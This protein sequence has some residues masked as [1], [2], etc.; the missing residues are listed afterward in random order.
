MTQRRLPG[1]RVA[2]ALCMS[3]LCSLLLLPYS[4]P[5]AAHGGGTP[6][7]T[8]VPVGPYHLYAWSDPEPWRAGEVHLSL[9][10]TRPNPDTSSNQVEIPVTDV[11]ITVTYTP[12]DN[13]GIDSSSAPVV[14]KAVRQEFLSDFYYEADP[15]LERV[16]DWQ[17]TIDVAGPDGS[18][19][20]Q[21]PMETLPA[22]SL[23]WTLIGAAGGVVVVALALLAIWS[24]SQ[25]PVQ[26][27]HR[28]HRGV[29][30]VEN[31]GKVAAGKKATNRVNSINRS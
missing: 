13:N 23:N 22:R 14:V 7:L 31:R 15:V 29:R 8:N 10:V 19:S 3:L 9:A 16:G 21:F 2:I 27:A 5:L 24:R 20:T 30:R 26:P 6:R 28:Q 12:V 25:Q 18:G 1:R 11:E 17:I 4:R